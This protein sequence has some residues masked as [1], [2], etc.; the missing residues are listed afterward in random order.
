MK[1][2][3]VHTH[4]HLLRLLKAPNHMVLMIGDAAKHQPPDK[5]DT[6]VVLE[7]NERFFQLIRDRFHKTPVFPILGNNDLPGLFFDNCL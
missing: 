3:A 2:N 7:N 4:T 5:W 1:T 6:A